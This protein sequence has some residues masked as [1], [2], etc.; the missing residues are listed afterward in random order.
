MWSLNSSSFNLSSTRVKG[1][2]NLRHY[3]DRETG[4]YVAVE[5]LL[6]TLGY[7]N[8]TLA[9]GVPSQ[10]KEPFIEGLVRLITELGGVTSAIVPDNSKCADGDIENIGSMEKVKAYLGQKRPNKRW[11]NILVKEESPAVRPPST[12]VR[13]VDIKVN[14]QF[15][16]KSL[17][18]PGIQYVCSKLPERKSKKSFSFSISVNGRISPTSKRISPS[19]FIG[20][21]LRHFLLIGNSR[22]RSEQY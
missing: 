11:I 16:D 13:A 18:I 15:F 8:Y 7:S 6:I 4:K 2:N 22:C 1:R 19:G 14:G 20:F 21:A 5:I 9:I 10:A 12:D 3:T 17:D